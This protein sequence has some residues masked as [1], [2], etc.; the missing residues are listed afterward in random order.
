MKLVKFLKSRR[1]DCHHWPIKTIPL[2]EKG[3]AANPY[4]YGWG[5]TQSGS[6]FAG[7]QSWFNTGWCVPFSPIFPGQPPL[8]EQRQIARPVKKKNQPK[9]IT[10]DMLHGSNTIRSFTLWLN[11]M[12]GHSVSRSN[13]QQQQLQPLQHQHQHQLLLS[14]Y[15]GGA[16]IVILRKP[17]NGILLQIKLGTTRKRILLGRLKL[18]N[19]LQ[20]HKQQQMQPGANRQFTQMLGGQLLHQLQLL[21]L[22][23]SRRQRK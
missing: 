2:A 13:K 5:V 20:L 7:A 17:I 12:I 23:L 21:Q 22:Q 11:E 4:Q 3:M 14:Q 15:Q 18:G 1:R 6:T 19:S 10:R 9:T 16:N 8:L